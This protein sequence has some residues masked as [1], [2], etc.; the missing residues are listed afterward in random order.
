MRSDNRRARPGPFDPERRR[1]LR[2]AVVAPATL[3]MWP[4]GPAQAQG[5]AASA[6]GGSSL[7]PLAQI[8]IEPN[9]SVVIEL[10]KLEMGQGAQSGLAQLIA[11]EMDADWSTVRVV[12][13]IAAPHL[14]DPRVGM[15]VTGGSHSIRHQWDSHREL[16]ARMRWLLLQAAAERF[17]TDPGRLRT[18][19][20]RVFFGTR[21]VTY[22]SLREALGERALPKQVELKPP[23]QYRLIGRPLTRIDARDKLTGKTRY[24]VDLMAGEV[25]VAVILRPARFGARVARWDWV[26]GSAPTGVLAAFEVDLVPSGQGVAIVARST[27]IALR[28][29]DAIRV[30]W[31]EPGHDAVDSDRLAQEWLALTQT[32]GRVVA[33]RSLPVPAE[34]ARTV[35]LTWVFPYLAH[36]AM[37][38]LN[39]TVLLATDRVEVWTGTQF[40]TVDQAAIAR[41]CGCEPDRVVLHTLP[42]GGAFGRRATPGSDV[43]VQAC[44]VAL[45]AR[46]AGHDGPVKLIWSREDDTGSGHYRPMH[47]HRACLHLDDTGRLRLWHHRMAGQSLLK[48]TPFESGLGA[49][50]VDTASTEGLADTPY[51]LPIRLEVH[52]P[53]NAIPVLWWRAVGHNHTAHVVETVMDELARA[54][55]EDPVGFRLARLPAGHRGVAALKLAA[56][57]S[58]YGRAMPPGQALGVAMH[59]CFGTAVA[60]VVRVSLEQGAWRLHEV[61]AGVHAGRVINPSSARAQIEG[62]VVMALGTLLQG[63]SM[64]I[65]DGAPINTGLNTLRLPRMTEMPSVSVYF[66][67]SEEEPGGMGEPGLPP[68]G[69]AVSNA[70]ARLSGRHWNHLPHPAP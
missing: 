7:H 38:P 40:Q 57:R 67:P 30:E 24:G 70:L 22:A 3:A 66:V 64:V 20:G 45:G 2:F 29:R 37:E 47:V 14:V 44:R 56:E 10:G 6:S 39:A 69:P 65:R 51:Q 35:E 4:A 50:G 13:G 8:R 18:H 58:G 43:V 27:F 41:T 15:Q 59:T 34:T 54:T 60:M 1:F 49:D 28:A 12:T 52:H 26:G 9:G 11:E 48:G 68:L 62:S 33:H 21:S 42:A 5:P 16:G 36:A 63:G 31:S 25:A 23:G 55:G 46:A 61:V 53:E 19:N 32:D 17:G